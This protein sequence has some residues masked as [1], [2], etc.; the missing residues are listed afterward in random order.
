MNA[1]TTL[2][3]SRDLES[4]RSNIKRFSVQAYYY[5]LKFLHFSCLNNNAVR[6]QAITVSE[7]Y[8][9]A[10]NGLLRTGYKSSGALNILIRVNEKA[11]FEAEKDYSESQRMKHA[12]ENRVEG[13]SF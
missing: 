12:F 9:D 2:T 4:I 8:D 11:R 6:S 13:L 7:N 5:S 10:F 1:Y 3:L